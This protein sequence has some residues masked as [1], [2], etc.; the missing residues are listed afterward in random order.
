M[1]YVCILSYGCAKRY[2][3]WYTQLIEWY[4]PTVSINGISSV[5]FIFAGKPCYRKLEIV[6][7][8]NP[9]IPNTKETGRFEVP[10]SK[11]DN[12]LGK[13]DKLKKFCDRGSVSQRPL[14]ITICETNEI[15]VIY[16]LY[17]LIWENLLCVMN[18]SGQTARWGDPPH[19]C[20]CLYGQRFF[21]RTSQRWPPL[22]VWR[23]R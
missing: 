22:S 1:V 9:F 18:V 23:A 7:S 17:P 19:Q 15:S 10:I 21:H 4:N 20:C 16:K 5:L 2:L 8:S 3:I 11:W 6:R 14:T 12:A 13:K